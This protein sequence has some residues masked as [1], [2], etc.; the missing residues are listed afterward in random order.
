MRFFNAKNKISAPC[1]QVSTIEKTDFFVD[2]PVKPSYYAVCLVKKQNLSMLYAIL[3]NPSFTSALLI[4][5][6]LRMRFLVR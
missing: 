4:P 1:F 6:N 3:R 2:F 5:M